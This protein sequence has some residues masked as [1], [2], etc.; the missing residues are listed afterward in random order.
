MRVL[1]VSPAVVVILRGEG[2]QR[3]LCVVNVT[4]AP[5]AVAVRDAG[6]DVGTWRDALSRRRFA[7]RD[8]WLDLELAPYDVVWLTAAGV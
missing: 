4:A 2:R 5:Q 7:A 6:Q 8:G 3:V 1:D